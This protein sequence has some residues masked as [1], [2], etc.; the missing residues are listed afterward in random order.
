MN[1][2]DALGWS[3]LHFLWEGATIAV[4][5]TGRADDHDHES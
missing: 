3:L 5:G 4:L 2:I 1:W